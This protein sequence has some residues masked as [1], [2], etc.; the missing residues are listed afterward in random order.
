M[1]TLNQENIL[2]HIQLAGLA[3]FSLRHKNR[4]FLHPILRK[5]AHKK[6][7]PKAGTVFLFVGLII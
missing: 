4:R 5:Y 6:T 7:V 3:A 1:K 2:K